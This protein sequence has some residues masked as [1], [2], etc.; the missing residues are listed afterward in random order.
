MVTL[1]RKIKVIES[2]PPEDNKNFEFRLNE[3]N[4]NRDENFLKYLK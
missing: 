4:I 2:L 3:H 1:K